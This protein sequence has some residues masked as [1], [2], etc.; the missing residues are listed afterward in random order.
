MKAALLLLLA[1][2][3]SRNLSDDDYTKIGLAAFL[4]VF[5]LPVALLI[6]WRVYRGHKQKKEYEQARRNAHSFKPPNVH[7]SAGVASKDD[8]RRKG[9]LK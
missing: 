2:T 6:L 7:G 9:W 3:Y 1:Q 4:T 5:A 8:A